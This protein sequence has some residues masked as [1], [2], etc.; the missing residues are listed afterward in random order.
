MQSRSSTAKSSLSAEESTGSATVRKAGADVRDAAGEIT[1]TAEALPIFKCREWIRIY[2]DKVIEHLM[3]P[4]NA[5]NMPDADA[6]G[7]VGDPEC[8]DA[9]TFYLKVSDGVIFDISYLVFGCCAAIATSSA[10]SVLAKGK[11]LRE[12]L[13]ITEDDVVNAL[14]GLPE[15]KVHCSLLGVSALRCAIFDYCEKNNIDVT[16]EI[17]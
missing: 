1:A 15:S 13:D 3:S 4:Q 11:S 9:L 6:E 10:T 2:S 8:G 14:D 7:T 17:K 5:R 12:A 16:E